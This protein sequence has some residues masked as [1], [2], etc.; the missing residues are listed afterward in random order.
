MGAIYRIYNTVTGGSYI[1]QSDSPYARIKQH[2]TPLGSNGSREIQADLLSLPPE[3]WQWEIVAD[4]KDYLHISLDT[5]EDLFIMFYDAITHGYNIKSGGG[6]ASGDIQDE[7][8]LRK[9]MRVEIVRK[10]SDYQKSH[11]KKLLINEGR[12]QIKLRT[13]A[14]QPD[15][16]LI[17]LINDSAFGSD[18]KTF[19]D[20]KSKFEEEQALN[21]AKKAR[22]QIEDLLATDKLKD[23]INKIEQDFMTVLYKTSELGRQYAMLQFSF[24]YKVEKKRCE[25]MGN[26]ADGFKEAINKIEKNLTTKF[27][28]IREDIRPDIFIQLSFKWKVGRVEDGEE[29]DL[30][31][32]IQHLRVCMRGGVMNRNVR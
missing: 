14:N 25:L 29:V 21:E 30:G 16:V 6:P 9:G 5:L 27:Y 19:E 31:S 13:L 10:I 1:G 26:C 7:T 22:K 17:Q 2:L 23:A 11:R 3:S 12:E 8:E 4:E 24:Q 18:I 20:L 32:C 28:E 15:H